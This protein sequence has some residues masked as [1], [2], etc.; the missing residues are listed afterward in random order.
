M[1]LT[2][3]EIQKTLTESMKSMQDTM[4]KERKGFNSKIESLEA[5]I[6]DKENLITNLTK[7]KPR[8]S[9]I[10]NLEQE[11]EQLKRKCKNKK[12]KN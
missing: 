4:E 2:I 1:S 11:N 10:K 6:R 5:I 9:I 12:I 8:D 7:K 3:E